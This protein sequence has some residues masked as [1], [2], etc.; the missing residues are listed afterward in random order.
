MVVLFLSL[1]GGYECK[2]DLHHYGVII[3]I[4]FRN[5][6]DLTVLCL[7]SPFSM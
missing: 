7:L 2:K 3:I 5:T 1:L 4:I 6:F